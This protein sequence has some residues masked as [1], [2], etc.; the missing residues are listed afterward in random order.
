M[1]H[2]TVRQ[3]FIEE[4]EASKVALGKNQEK[5]GAKEDKQGKIQIQLAVSGKG[6]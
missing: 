3:C 4:K 6:L 5:I 1:L 2:F